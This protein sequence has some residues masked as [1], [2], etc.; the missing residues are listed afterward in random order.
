MRNRCSEKLRIFSKVILRFKFVFDF[1]EEVE[2]GR[3]EVVQT[4]TFF[5]EN[6][7]EAAQ[8]FFDEDATEAGFELEKRVIFESALDAIEIEARNFFFDGALH[9]IVEEDG[10]TVVFFVF[11]DHAGSEVDNFVFMEGN[12]ATGNNGVVVL[13]SDDVKFGFRPEG[14]KNLFEVIYLS[15]HDAVFLVAVV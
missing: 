2:D 13:F 11:L 14:V 4:I 10:G 7:F 3:F 15:A 8:I 1:S 5:I 12:E 9:S 6:K